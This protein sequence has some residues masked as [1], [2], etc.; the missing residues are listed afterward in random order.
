MSK[1]IRVADQS[2]MV[3]TISRLKAEGFRFEAIAANDA[4]DTAKVPVIIAYKDAET[5]NVRFNEMAAGH[6]FYG[7]RAAVEARDMAISI[8]AELDKPAAA[9]ECPACTWPELTEYEKSEAHFRGFPRGADI[10]YIAKRKYDQEAGEMSLVR[11]TRVFDKPAAAQSEDL[12]RMPYATKAEAVAAIK[13]AGF[14]MERNDSGN[15]DKF[16]TVTDGE[17]PGMYNHYARP[18]FDPAA[19]HWVILIDVNR[20]ADLDK[21]AIETAAAEVLNR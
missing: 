10:R 3:A 1:F 11:W 15:G 18:V 9:N 17:F 12:Q 4:T 19:G 8:I 20:F 6:S 2:A 5:V 13:A 14:E 7:R 21:L 16:E